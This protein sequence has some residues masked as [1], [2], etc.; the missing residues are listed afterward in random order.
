MGLRFLHLNQILHL[1]SQT[2]R[3]NTSRRVVKA[4]VITDFSP[5]NHC[6]L[7]MFIC[8]YMCMCVYFM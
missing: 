6:A 4:I 8:V 5:F 7:Y 3:N 2:V 1:N